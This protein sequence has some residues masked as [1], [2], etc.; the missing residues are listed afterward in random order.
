MEQDIVKQWANFGHIVLCRLLCSCVH[1]HVSRARQ[2]L[3]FTARQQCMHAG[4][5]GLYLDGSLAGEVVCSR[6]PYSSLCLTVS[7]DT[8]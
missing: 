5:H 1:L 2:R 6:A 7:I 4:L 8:R 3:T